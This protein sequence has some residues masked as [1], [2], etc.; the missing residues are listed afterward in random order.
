MPSKES[1]LVCANRPR[2]S[3][4]TDRRRGP[5]ACDTCAQLAHIHWYST[6]STTLL[7]PAAAPFPAL[8]LCLASAPRA[9][10]RGRPSPCTPE[11]DLPPGQLLAPECL[12]VLA[13][14]PAPLSGTARRRCL[15][16]RP[17]I[18]GPFAVHAPR[19][20]SASA[21]RGWCKP[22]GR[23]RLAVGGEPVGKGALAGPKPWLLHAA[24]AGAPPPR[25][26]M[27]LTVPDLVA[28]P[29]PGSGPLS[30]H[31]RLGQRARPVP[32]RIESA[33]GFGSRP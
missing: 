21:R 28:A 9:L 25:A 19:R 10:G 27:T 14:C 24:A 13:S 8:G 1:R 6:Y 15:P 3:W 11:L 20:A 22:L 12:P 18:L 33:R 4:T 7:L 31:M 5:P 32:A 29:L 17:H 26:S 30:A 23:A 16:S 2:G